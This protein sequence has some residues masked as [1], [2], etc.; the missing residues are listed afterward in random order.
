MVKIARYPSCSVDLTDLVRPEPNACHV[1]LKF[2]AFRWMVRCATAFRAKHYDLCESTHGPIE[3]LSV[4]SARGLR[5]V[6]PI[7]SGQCLGVGNCSP[8]QWESHLRNALTDALLGYPNDA[9][10]AWRKQYGLFV[11]RRVTLRCPATAGLRNGNMCDNGSFVVKRDLKA[12]L[13]MRGI[14]AKGYNTCHPR[15][16]SVHG[17]ELVPETWPRSHWFCRINYGYPCDGTC[18]SLWRVT[19]ARQERREA[20]PNFVARALAEFRSLL[21]SV[22]SAADVA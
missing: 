19:I 22:E 2:E 10:S 18:P 12:L 8:D 14:L 4:T 7:C 17:V 13:S 3:A 9:L 16:R 15:A 21:A 20:F 6:T 11:Y 1:A 5:E